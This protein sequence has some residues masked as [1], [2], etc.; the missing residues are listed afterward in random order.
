MSTQYVHSS[1]KLWE[2]LLLKLS[3]LRKEGM[4]IQGL[5]FICRPGQNSVFMASFL[6]LQG[7]ERKRILSF[8]SFLGVQWSR[9]PLLMQGTWVQSLVQ[10]DSTCHGASEHMHHSY[11][12]HVQLY[13]YPPCTREALTVRSPC[14]Q[15]RVSPTH[16][17][18][19]KPEHSNED[20][21]QPKINQN[22]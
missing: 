17:N 13:A 19:R 5:K 20:A 11:W 8:W 15:G 10:E 12:V 18:Q 14:I 21:V 2:F 4:L 9:I 22:K 16:H 6:L 1:W 7:Q 3:L